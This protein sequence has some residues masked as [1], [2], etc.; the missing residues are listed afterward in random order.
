MSLV[1]LLLITAS[2]L[3]L[4]GSS[5]TIELDLSQE[6][7]SPG[8]KGFYNVE[9]NE[10]FAYRWSKPTWELTLDDL[11][12]ARPYQLYLSAL[13]PTPEIV[14]V[15]DSSSGHVLTSL[16]P[17][18]QWQ[19]LPLEIPPEVVVDGRLHL[20][21][22]VPAFVPASPDDPRKLGL[23]VTSIKLK[24]VE[25]RDL[26][27]IRYILWGGAGLLC[28]LLLV[29]ALIKLVYSLLENTTLLG[30]SLAKAQTRSGASAS[31]WLAGVALFGLVLR[32]ANPLSL[33]IFIDESF[34]IWAGFAAQTGKLD[35]TGLFATAIDSKVLHGWLLAA[36]FQLVGTGQPLLLA[37]LFSALCGLITLLTCYSLATH[38]FSSQRA[39]LLAAALWGLLPYALWHE[40]MALVDPL[41]T[42][43]TV[44]ALYFGLRLLEGTGQKVVAGYGMLT[45]LALATAVLTKIPALL[46]GVMPVIAL[47]A[48]YPLKSWLR[49]GKRL[50][51]VYVVGG[52]P[53]LLVIALY[54]GR[55]SGG[56]QADKLSPPQLDLFLNNLGQMTEWSYAYFTFPLLLLVIVGVRF[57]LLSNWRV[58]LFLLVAT[59]LPWLVFCLI[60]QVIYPRYLLIALPPLVVLTA[61]GIAALVDKLTDK[62]ALQLSL[63]GLFLV[64]LP[65]IWFDFQTIIDPYKTALPAVDRFQYLEGWPAGGNVEQLTQFLI[66]KQKQAGNSI[67]VIEADY[68]SFRALDVYL[69]NYH[70]Q[71]GLIS[72]AGVAPGQ[73]GNKINAALETGPTFF[74]INNPRDLSTLQAYRWAFPKLD[75]QEIQTVN[76]PGQQY[77]LVTYQIC[78]NSCKKGG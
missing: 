68:I 70:P 57:A 78:S 38:L 10:V 9:R 24:P 3:S 1:P 28:L 73:M 64:S 5:L 21:F 59:L 53:T 66:E 2:L 34:H 58:S 39:G 50:A 63:L 22:S 30:S 77:R 17:G 40:R 18:S 61:G 65:A 29:Q 12:S 32:V 56:Q 7:L 42:A 67:T 6:K 72:V 46:F 33:S 76:R 69:V 16:T 45:G 31:W 23:M 20:T 41:M 74:V 44:S 71:I 51:L 37:R 62:R 11:E 52:L 35:S 60:G 13:R 36:L 25:S 55:W 26:T 19:T 75:F 27:L 43:C 47:L 14:K 4:A 15:I 48:L 49:L 8:L 54:N